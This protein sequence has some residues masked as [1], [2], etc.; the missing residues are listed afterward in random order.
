RRD[1]LWTMAGAAW[2]AALWFHPAA[3]V[4]VSRSALAREMRV[5]E[6]TMAYTR[7]RGAY[8]AALLTFSTATARPLAVATPFFG[9]R[10]L[11]DRIVHVTKEL[12]MHAGRSRTTLGIAIVVVTCMTG[13]AARQA[14][15]AWPAT[16]DR[17]PIAAAA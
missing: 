5:D 9:R 15:L 11:S 16:P 1:W 7:D 2:C 12:P 10:H 8:A 17:L 3:R 6:E 13:L 14:P 4:L